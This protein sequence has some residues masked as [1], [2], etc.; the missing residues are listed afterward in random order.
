MFEA[1][2]P[3]LASGDPG[4]GVEEVDCNGTD[5]VDANADGEVLITE[6]ED[7]PATCDGG[8]FWAKL[9]GGVKV[10]ANGEAAEKTFG[11]VNCASSR[12]IGYRYIFK[13]GGHH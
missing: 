13:G 6:I 12:T 11:T 1:V 5:C 7:G 4:S 3:D 2:D 10:D 9:R 8:G